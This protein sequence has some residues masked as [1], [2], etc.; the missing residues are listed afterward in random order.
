MLDKFRQ[1]YPNGS[2]ISELVQIDHGQY[3]VRV[4]L[5]NDG[6]TLVSALSSSGNLEE[7]ENQAIGRALSLLDL[8]KKSQLEPPK[9]HHVTQDIPFTSKSEPIGLVVEENYIQQQTEIVPEKSITNG[10][11]PSQL[12]LE[13]VKP[14]DNSEMIAMINMELKRLGWNT[15]KGRD[16]LLSTYGKKSRHMLSDQELMAFLEHLKSEPSDQ[17]EY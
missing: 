8:N 5:R 16:Y 15:E 12:P 3:I 4:L 14:M 10:H 2:L 1:C 7:A 17:Q 9:S 13:T 11:Q 6:K